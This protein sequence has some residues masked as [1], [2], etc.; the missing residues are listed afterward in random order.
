MKWNAVLEASALQQARLIATRQIS[1]EELTRIYLERIET[2]NPVLQAFVRVWPKSALKSAREKDAMVASGAA[3]PAFHGVPMGVKDLNMVRGHITR[4][5]SR[6]VAIPAPKD[7]NTTTALRRGGF[8]LLGKTSTSELGALP[9]TEP[10]NHPPTRNP[11]DQSRTSG[12]SSGGAGAAVAA[13]LLPLAQGSDGGGSI[14]IPAALNHLYGIKPSRGRV[15]NPYGLPDANIIYTCGPITRNVDDA[16]AMLDILCGLDVGKPH[17]LAP[18]SSTFARLCREKLPPLRIGVVVTNPVAPVHPRMKQAVEDVARILIGL[19][20]TT[21]EREV[22]D[23]SVNEFLP[24]WQ[25]QVAQAPV[26]VHNR[27][28]PVTRWLREPGKKLREADVLPIQQAMTQRLLGMMD[29]VDVLLTPTVGIPTPEVG[30][31]AGLPPDQAFYAAAAMGAFTAP[32]NITGAPSASIP[33]GLL[34]G[35]WP[36]AVQLTGRLGEDARVLALSRVLEEAMPWAGR[37][38]PLAGRPSSG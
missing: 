16:A 22:P 33:A 13:G 14:R 8:V 27:L 35:R 38:A 30:A 10:G 24:I 17:W 2:L 37:W 19:G 5:G 3:L 9:V 6:A 1:S 29:G 25:F 4:F 36:V 34:E 7:C 18:P 15:P 31:F 26:F 32:A 11:W 21:V 28:Q 23:I 12:G 20:H